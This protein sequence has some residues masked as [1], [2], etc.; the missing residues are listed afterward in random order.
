MNI[1]IQKPPIWE[2]AHK[3]FEI[4]D[5]RTIY[6][7]GDTIYNPSNVIIDP[8]VLEHESVHVR[9]QANTEGGPRAWWRHYFDDMSFRIGQEA[10]AYGR[11]YWSFCRHEK[12]RN[13]QTRYL[14]MI[15]GFLGSKMYGVEIK[16]SEALALIKAMANMVKE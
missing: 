9:Q 5:A 8:D 15:A 1:L 4:D 10:E 12:D 6:T 16:N 11:Q 13:K 3:H 2:E 14:Y 7:Y